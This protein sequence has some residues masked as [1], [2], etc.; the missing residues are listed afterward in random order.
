MKQIWLIGLFLG[1]VPLWASEI[2]TQPTPFSQ[3]RPGGPFPPG[4]VPT[5][6]AKVPR[7]T[8]FSMV[9]DE[10]R[11]VLRA[12]S[13]AA[14]SSLSFK[15][16]VDP[17]KT[18]KLSWRWKVSRVIE[19]SDLASKDGDDYAARVYVF[20]DYD[21]GRLSFLDRAAFGLARTLYGSDLPAATLCYVWDNRYPVGTSMP[22]AY[23]SH[24]RMVVVESGPDQVGHW[25]E[26]SRN[27]ADDF[28]SAFGDMAPPISGISIA[29]D[30]DNTGENVVT[31]FGDLVFLPAKA[32]RPE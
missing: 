32:A 7:T 8:E 1:T 25:V 24:V 17:N 18:P 14:A 15:L 6:I 21:I 26:E 28:R 16:R 23:T 30:T 9:E 29:A 19:K 27:V 31:H 5:I 11:T 10:G 3:S 2:F 12:T 22:S 20:F 4:W 13:D